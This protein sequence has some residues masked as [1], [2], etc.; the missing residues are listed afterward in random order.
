M[1]GVQVPKKNKSKYQTERGRRKKNHLH[2][3]QS[4][5]QRLWFIHMGK[6]A[7]LLWTPRLDRLAH[8]SWAAQGQT[9]PC[10]MYRKRYRPNSCSLQEASLPEPGLHKPHSPSKVTTRLNHS[11][12][13]G[14]AR[15]AEI[16]SGVVLSV[17]LSPHSRNSQRLQA[18]YDGRAD[19][20]A[21]LIALYSQ[22]LSP[23]TR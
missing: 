10:E 16:G 23:P 5:E 6:W 2:Y 22:R 11:S 17:K 1:L 4:W 3:W 21:I 13:L 9:W 15:E 7:F 19:H 12:P 14:G 8:L 18:V 20:S